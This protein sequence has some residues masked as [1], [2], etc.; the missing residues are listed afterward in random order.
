MTNSNESA[1]SS[2]WDALEASVRKEVQES[3][4][5]EVDAKHT[6]LVWN[7]MLGELQ[8][9]EVTVATE[10]TIRESKRRRELSFRAVLAIAASGLL[11]TLSSVF[12]VALKHRRDGTVASTVTHVEH[13]MRKNR[14]VERA[15]HDWLPEEREIW[16][17]MMSQSAAGVDPDQA[18]V[19]EK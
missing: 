3:T 12:L 8:R 15:S 14:S 9:D 1:D 13:L 17:K 11:L 7:S 5:F 18:V 2:E 19:L 4:A 6:A 10:H 16:K